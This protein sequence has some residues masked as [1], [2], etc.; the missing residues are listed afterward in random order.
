VNLPRV[1]RREHGEPQRVV[2]A[3]C[4]LLVLGHTSG[5]RRLEQGGVLDDAV[6]LYL[7]ADRSTARGPLWVL[8][9]MVG[10]LAGSAA[11]DGRVGGLST[12]TDQAL[13]R[14]LREVADVVLVGAET[15]RRER[16]GPVHLDEAAQTR[17]RTRGM[18][19]VPPLAIVS[20]SL[21]LD[22]AGAA[23]TEVAAP[24]IVVTC[25][26]AP[27][28][29]LAAARN[30]AEVI[31]A[32][33]ERVGVGTALIALAGRG[34]GVVLCE[35]GPTLLGELAAADLLDELCLTLS[36]IVGGDP[37]PIAV[38]PPGTRFHGYR[39]GHV[40]IDDEDALFLRYT[41]READREP[42]G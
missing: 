13:F 28:D 14:A 17:R 3:G 42:A 41:R 1:P 31:I 21:E 29:H 9:N 11:A 36:P 19:P 10:S 8:A 32:G 35:G 34:Y 30:A 12:S 26:A 18:A 5:V 33:D 39:L 37:L 22:F 7:D 16:Y 2:L 38:L 4:S 20:R 24:T 23:F 6:E 25:D 40:L 27:P 15:V